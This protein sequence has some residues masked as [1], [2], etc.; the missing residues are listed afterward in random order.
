MKISVSLSKESVDEAIQKVDIY[1]QNVQGIAEKLAER[2]AGIGATR[3]SI[4]FSRAISDDTQKP[5]S[6][7][8]VPK[9]GG[10]S[11]VVSGQDVCF[12]EF[13]AGVRYG[14]GYPGERPAGVVGIGEY[15]NG[16]GNNPNGW[17][18][19]D[20]GGQARHSYGNPPNAVMYRTGQELRQEILRIAK[21][22]FQ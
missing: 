14:N 12:L 15:G 4:G 20:A 3:V 21:E 7:D 2:L 8:V 5:F 16:K 17:W 18:Y 13:G 11:I 9:D 19:R 10:Y 1:K 22:I 6:V